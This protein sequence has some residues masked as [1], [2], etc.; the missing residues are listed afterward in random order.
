MDVFADNLCPGLRRQLAEH[1]ELH[2]LRDSVEQSDGALQ[3]RVVHQAAVDHVALV[4]SSVGL[5]STSP[6]LSASDVFPE[7]PEVNARNT[8]HEAD[9]SL[10]GVAS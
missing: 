4:A 3:S 10:R 9:V 1:H 7:P 5:D 2:P 8:K 6:G